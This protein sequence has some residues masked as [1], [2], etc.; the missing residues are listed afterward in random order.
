[1]LKDD[2]L[3]ALEIDS[4]RVITQNWRK[5]AEDELGETDQLREMALIE[6]RVRVRSLPN[7]VPR[8]DDD[9]LIRFLRAKKYDQDKA[10]RLYRNFFRVRLFD[11]NVYSPMGKGP[12][13]FQHL[14]NL[15]VGHL[16]RHRNPINGACVLVWQFGDWTPETGYD[17][18]HIYTP[19]QFCVDFAMRD[20]E[21]QLNGFMFIINLIGLEW[22][23]LKVFGVNAV[24][25]SF[26]LRV[27]A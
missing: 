12:K 8:L 7:L 17:L 27:K 11:P 22:R 21:V 5:R 4:N 23:Y 24:R 18:S 2:D 6:F 10:L 19:T 3:K 15:N 16:L 13:D 1:M 26:P 20:P 14:Y 25:V 9:F